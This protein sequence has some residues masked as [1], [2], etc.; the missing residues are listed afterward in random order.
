MI[1]VPF[2][3]VICWRASVA[4]AEGKAGRPYVV[5]RSLVGHLAVVSNGLKQCVYVCVCV[6]LDTYHHAVTRVQ[7]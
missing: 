3:L 5:A 1:R 2:R 7:S 6:T 4:M